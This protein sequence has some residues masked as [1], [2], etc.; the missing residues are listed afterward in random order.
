MP[1]EVLMSYRRIAVD[2]GGPDVLRCVEVDVPEPETGQVQIDVRASGMN[3]ADAKRVAP[4]QASSS[5][6]ERSAS[7]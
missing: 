6:R 4:G 3:P 1:A 7:G 2:F 5:R